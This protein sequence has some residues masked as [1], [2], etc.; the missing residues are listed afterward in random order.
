MAQWRHLVGLMTVLAL[1]VGAGTSA[2][3]Q[4]QPA[5]P[6]ALDIVTGALF[7]CLPVA[8]EPWTKDLCAA[9]STEAGSLAKAAKLR[10]VGLTTQDTDATNKQ[11]A[12]EAGFD[13]A[14]AL[15]LLVKVQRMSPGS[16]PGWNI[17]LQ[18]DASTLP[19]PLNKGQSLRLVFTQGA[20]L[21]AGVSRREAENAGKMLLEAFFE[22]FSKPMK[23]PA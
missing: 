2:P 3:A 12:R 13:P 11:K 22:I 23:P 20:T 18:A 8:T 5:P 15:W 14:N 7:Y 4:D 19:H 21:D 17:S 10:F 6:R 9:M 16:R 1:F